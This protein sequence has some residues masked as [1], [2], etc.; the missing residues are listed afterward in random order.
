MLDQCQRISFVSIYSY[1]IPYTT[2]LCLLYLV[3]CLH[4][5]QL[6]VRGPDRMHHRRRSSVVELVRLHNGDTFG[7]CLWFCCVSHLVTQCLFGCLHDSYRWSITPSS[8]PSGLTIVPNPVATCRSRPMPPTRR[9]LWLRIPVPPLPRIIHY[10]ATARLM[11]RPIDR[12]TR[13]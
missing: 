13:K 1:T 6:H 3:D 5:L 7:I 10:R 12:T 11:A 4:C 9:V 8:F 2:I